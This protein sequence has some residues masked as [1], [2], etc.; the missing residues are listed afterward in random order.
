MVSGIGNTT[1]DNIQ[2]LMA[3]LYQKMNAADTD[4][5]VGLSI[6]E[7]SSVDAGDD[8]GGSAFLKSL[9]E[10]FDTL[11][12]DGNGQLTSDEISSAKPPVGQMGPP[13]WLS[14]ESSNRQSSDSVTVDNWAES[15]GVS[16]SKLSNSL[17][18]KLINSYKDGSLSNLLSSLDIAI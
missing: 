6:D 15:L 12:A 11:D 5:T 1:D 17:L 13:P 3:Q 8:I 4:G 10:Q 14:M 2:L 16:F 9:N 7:L 18:D